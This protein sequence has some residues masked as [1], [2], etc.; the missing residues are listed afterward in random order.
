MALAQGAG[1]AEFLEHLFIGHGAVNSPERASVEHWKPMPPPAL[2]A[3][4]TPRL[5][6]R[7]TEPG[8]AA[9]FLEIQ[10][11]W[12]VMRMLRAASY[13]PT[14]ES[15]A[16][17]L[18]SH[19]GE[20]SDGAAYRFT[21]MEEGRVIGCADV[22][23]IESGHGDLGYWLEAPAWGRGL[24]TE[25]ATAL[26]DFAFGTPGLETLLSGHAADNPASGFFVL[27][28]LGFRRTGEA[29]L[30]SIPRQTEILQRQYRLDR[31]AP[32]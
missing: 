24:A 15:L 31:T 12:Q 6:L 21:V 7:P 4:K 22:D 13:P 3:L 32:L 20:W 19:A 1:L 16:A 8:D 17:W 26:R 30:W 2:I 27:L 23:E 18:G 10:S 11:D 5:R 14:L 28:K 9:R 29:T 25:A